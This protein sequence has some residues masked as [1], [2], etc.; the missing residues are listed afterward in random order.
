[1]ERHPGRADELVRRFG[2]DGVVVVRAD[3]ADLRLPRRP[4]H[5]VANPPFS[6]TSALLRRLLHP[7]SRLVSAHLVLQA[8]AARSWAA[9][10]APGRGRWGRSYEAALGA[11]I[12]RSAFDPRP[13]VDA[14]VLAVRSRIRQGTGQRV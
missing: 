8:Q 10:D 5:V 3:A 1:V 9:P 13:Q 4:F 2:A 12:P 11:R 14:R 6:V 7:S